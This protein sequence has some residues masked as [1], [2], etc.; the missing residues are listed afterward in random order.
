MSNFACVH[1]GGAWDADIVYQVF[2]RRPEDQ[3]CRSCRKAGHTANSGPCLACR[4]YRRDQRVPAA[5]AAKRRP[6]LTL[7]DAVPLVG[8][9]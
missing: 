6:Q 8:D 1:C 5:P 2:G 4:S 3:L 7:V 9:E